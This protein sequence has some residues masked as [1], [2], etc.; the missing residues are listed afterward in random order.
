MTAEPFSV[1]GFQD[2][3]TDPLSVHGADLVPT[4][5]VLFS[6]LTR[7]LNGGSQGQEIDKRCGRMVWQMH[8]QRP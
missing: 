6:E 1:V 7:L 2:L 8:C 5:T 4:C 3:L